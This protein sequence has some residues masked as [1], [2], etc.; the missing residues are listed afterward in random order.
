SGCSARGPTPSPAGTPGA[1]AAEDISER[2]LLEPL[3]R[4]GL[5]E[6]NALT[7]PRPF[8]A[9][10]G[11]PPPARPRRPAQRPGRRR[12]PART[13]G[14]GSPRRDSRSAPAPLTPPPGGRR[15]NPTPAIISLP[16]TQPVKHNP[17]S[18]CVFLAA[19]SSAVQ[20]PPEAL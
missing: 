18:A 16:R 13:T 3:G 7:P 11:K 14:R 20:S 9:T 6:E 19:V 17:G 2:A 15:E 5:R 8:P 1:R 12:P 10:C 4:G